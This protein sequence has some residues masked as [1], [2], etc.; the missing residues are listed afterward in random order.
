MVI[1]AGSFGTLD[2]NPKNITL[3]A[4][5]SEGI[6]VAGGFQ[7]CLTTYFGCQ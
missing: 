2:V 5:F 7:Y 6:G 1:G 3:G 4:G